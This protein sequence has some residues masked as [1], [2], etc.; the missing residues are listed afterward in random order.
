VGGIAVVILVMIMAGLYMI[1]R[2]RSSDLDG[3]A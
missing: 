1:L 3:D 2:N